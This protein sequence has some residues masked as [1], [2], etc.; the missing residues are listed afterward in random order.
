MNSL[1]YF[2]ITAAAPILLNICLILALLIAR[3]LQFDIGWAIT[4]AIPIAGI[5]Q[6][7][8]IALVCYIR[9]L[10]PRISI[11]RINPETK[12]FL[13]LEISSSLKSFSK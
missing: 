7:V 8:A 10:L 5:L 1:G 9:G 13:L 4:Y 2:G 6:M 11:P 12:N 3:N